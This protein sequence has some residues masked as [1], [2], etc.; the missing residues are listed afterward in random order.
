MSTL[1]ESV[2]RYLLPLYRA[3]VAKELIEKHNYTQVQAAKKLGTTQAAISQYMT[4][5]RGHRRIP[6]YEEIA[7]LVQ[8]AAAKAAERIATTKMSPEE[9]SASF[10][11][12]C[13][14]LQRNRK[15][16]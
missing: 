5:K 2:A 12:L 1:C 14:S 9:F 15:F 13:K 4:S 10:C 11:E 8:N 16:L 6:N 3:F 7:P